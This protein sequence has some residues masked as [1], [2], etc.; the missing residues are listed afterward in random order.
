MGIPSGPACLPEFIPSIARDIS[1]LFIP[2][3]K[4]TLESYEI[5]RIFSALIFLSRYHHY[6]LGNHRTSDSSL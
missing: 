6:F 5:A 4:L 2:I 3:F 1:T